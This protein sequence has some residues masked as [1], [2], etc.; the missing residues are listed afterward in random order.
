MNKSLVLTFLSLLIFC[1]SSSAHTDV[2]K[3]P[4][5]TIEQEDFFS[6]NIPVYAY[7]SKIYTEGKTPEQMAKEYDLSTK[8]NQKYLKALENI[9][10]IEKVNYD[11][12]SSP[13]H[14]LVTG[15]STYSPG[16][17]LSNKFTELMLKDYYEKMLRL[18]G[19][20]NT[21]FYLST[22]GLWLTE[23]EYE[24][25]KKGLKELEEKYIDVSIKTR[26]SKNKGAFRVSSFIGV[27][28]KWEPHIFHEVKKDY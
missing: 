9:G 27:I 6:L 4:F 2:P 11:D 24:Q 3:K 26:K 5:F 17:P 25:Y 18:T 7:F 20:K 22:P 23:K 1:I 14:F 28:P 13:L 16:G 8:T 21:E 15:V 10:V 12:L 19:E